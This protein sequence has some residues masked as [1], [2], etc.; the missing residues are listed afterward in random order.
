MTTWY[1]IDIDDEV[2]VKQTLQRVMDEFTPKYI[3]AGRPLTMAV[4]SSHNSES[5]TVTLYFSPK[6]A[7]L[8]MRFGASPCD[9]V[10][11]DQELSLLVGDERSID[12]L[13]P[14]AGTK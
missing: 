7:S 2:A 5:N 4:F 8:A 10:F 11:V 6:A 3:G 1:S 14:D 9:G 12:L 13:F